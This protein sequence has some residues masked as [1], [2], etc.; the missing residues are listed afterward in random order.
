MK[1]TSLNEG[2]VRRWFRNYGYVTRITC[3]EGRAKVRWFHGSTYHMVEVIHGVTVDIPPRNW[4]GYEAIDGPATVIEVH[5]LATP[6][7][8]WQEVADEDTAGVRW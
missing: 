6:V 8:Q 3:E 7:E 2:E 4:Y 5:D 1:I